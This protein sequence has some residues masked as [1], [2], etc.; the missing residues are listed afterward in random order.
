[1]KKI[2]YFMAAALALGSCQQDNIVMD[3][4]ASSQL[5]EGQYAITAS[6]KPSSR[7]DINGFKTTWS[8]TDAITIFD[9]YGEKAICPLKAESAGTA[10]GVFL[11]TIDPS[12]AAEGVAFPATAQPVLCESQDTLYYT[13]PSTYEVGDNSQNAPMLG[14]FNTSNQIEFSYLT[15]MLKVKISGIPEGYNTL[16]FI[17]KGDHTQLAGVFKTTVPF[18]AED[19]FVCHTNGTSVVKITHADNKGEYYLP[20]QASKYDELHISAL[21]AE[22]KEIQLYTLF[23]KVFEIGKI[24]NL[25]RT[26]KSL[27]NITAP[28]EMISGLPTK[29]NFID[30]WTK[31]SGFD[32]RATY[33][34]VDNAPSMVWPQSMLIEH[35]ADDRW[36]HTFIFSFDNTSNII[37]PK[38]YKVS[39]KMMTDVK[40]G[41]KLCN[42]VSESDPNPQVDKRQQDTFPVVIHTK[43]KDTGEKYINYQAWQTKLSADD[44]ADCYVIVD[45]GMNKIMGWGGSSSK[46]SDFR[47]TAGTEFMKYI[48]L[49]FVPQTNAGIG[50]KTY[51]SDVQISEVVE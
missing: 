6:I 24:Y 17:A 16:K 39:F 49:Y 48:S 35:T 27:V 22:G 51:I 7:I 50:D 37:L 30:G 44:Y 12:E 26:Y 8:A 34:L 46:I 18:K 3:E 5:A 33:S 21:N 31:H 36:N 20:L 25:E 28:E 42:K 11:S 41:W 32:T 1:M 4:A 13:L 9:Y 29:D 43:K 45:F 23:D 19:G 47:Q 14:K 38:K 40:M 10:E 2:F 15:A